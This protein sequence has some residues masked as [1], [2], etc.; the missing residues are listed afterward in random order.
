MSGGK[1]GRWIGKRKV[2]TRHTGDTMP[3]HPH[4]GRLIRPADRMNPRAWRHE[5][6]GLVWLYHPYTGKARAEEEVNADPYMK[7]EF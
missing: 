2:A 7:S 3:F 5:Y 4:T 1:V 6:A